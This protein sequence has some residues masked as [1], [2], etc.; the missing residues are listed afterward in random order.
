LTMLKALKVLNALSGVESE[1]QMGG[2]RAKSTAMRAVAGFHKEVEAVEV[3]EGVE[4]LAIFMGNLAVSA[5][6]RIE[7]LEGVGALEGLGRSGGTT[8][9]RS[10][11]GKGV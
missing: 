6:E 3:L 9:V 11:L 1:P 2:L 4:G 10:W 5:S 7:V 8:L